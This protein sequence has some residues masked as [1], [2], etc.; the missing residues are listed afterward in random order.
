MEFFRLLRT[1][2]NNYNIKY[3]STI[4]LGNINYNNIIQKFENN[5]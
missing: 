4:Q 1:L 5:L 3:N 2:D